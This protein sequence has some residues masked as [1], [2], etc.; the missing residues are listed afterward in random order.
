MGDPGA[1]HW[2]GRPEDQCSHNIPSPAG[3]AGIA[4]YSGEVE[5]TDQALGSS[6]QAREPAQEGVASQRDRKQTQ[7]VPFA[8]DAAEDA[9]TKAEIAEG[10]L[11]VVVVVAA[12]AA[13]DNHM[14]VEE[15][16]R[17]DLID[18]EQSQ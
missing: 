5:K 18:S 16:W 13:A 12:A 4:R 15:P 3:V 10:P 11:R 1:A 6:A 2:Q 7:Q 17:K 8:A 9:T 14:R